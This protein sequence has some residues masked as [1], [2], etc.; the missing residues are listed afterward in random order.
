MSAL[1]L[2]LIA[3]GLIEIFGFIIAL[4]TLTGIIKQF[5]QDQ[6]KFKADTLDNLSDFLQLTKKSSKTAHEIFDNISQQN[7]LICEQYKTIGSQ[8]NLM[9]EVFKAQEDRYITICDH[10]STLLNAWKNVEERYSDCYEQLKY[11]K[12]WLAEEKTEQ[13]LDLC[14]NV[15]I[16]R[17]C[18]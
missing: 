16:S 14:P 18:Q 17:G 1:T 4:Y 10:Y 9:S 7:N 5:R 13:K 6:E 8:Y 11:L 3:V 15:T 2:I 12:D